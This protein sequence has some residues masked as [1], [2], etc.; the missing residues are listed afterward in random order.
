MTFLMQNSTN[1][2]P[3]KTGVIIERW[4]VAMLEVLV[5]VGT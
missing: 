5:R 4:G 3:L 2:I 1:R